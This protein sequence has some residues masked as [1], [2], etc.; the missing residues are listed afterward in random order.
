MKRKL[1][2]IL[3][4]TILLL[5][6]SIMLIVSEAV[7]AVKDIIENKVN[8]LADITLDKYENFDT[9]IENSDIGSKGVLA[10]FNLKT[11]IQ[12][13]DNENYVPIKQTKTNI[14]LPLIES[15]K[16]KRV[17][18]ITKSTQAT[19]GGKNANYKYDYSTG[20]LEI[21]A[22]N[23]EY[24]DNIADARDEY[25]IICIYSS[26]CYNQDKERDFK[27]K[28]NVE[29]TLDNE[30]ESKIY[31]TPEQEYNVKDKINGII[32]IEHKTDA[33]Y[34]GYI[35]ANALNSE[36]KYETKYNET[37]NII[38]SNKDI[39]PKI[40][41][42]ENSETSLYVESTID[43]NQ[44]LEILGDNGSIDILDDNEKILT[45]INKET[46]A[47]DNGKI[48]FTYEENKQNLNIRL[49]NIS[50]EGIIEINNVRVV[51]PT[52]VIT[53]NSIFTQ[54]T[55]NGISEVEIKKDIDTT[56][57]TEVIKEDKVVYTENNQIT[58]NI[59]KAKS[60]IDAKL[61]KYTL[62]NNT[63]NSLVYTAV[64]KA[65]GPQDSLAK[66]PNLQIQMPSGVENVEIGNAEIMYDNK[67]FKVIS[68][69]VTSNS[70]GNKVVNVQ[71]EGTQTTYENS[72]VIEGINIRIPLT[73]TLSKNIENQLGNITT[74]YSNDMNGTVAEKSTEVT[75]L[76]KIVNVARTVGAVNYNSATTA[77][78]LNETGTI[79]EQNG[80]KAEF[81]QEIGNNKLNNEATLY[82]EQIVKQSLKVT[83]TSNSVQNIKFTINVPDEMTYVIE[84]DDD[85][86]IYHEDKN[87]YE[88]SRRYE[89]IEQENKQV[90]LEMTVN[91]GET[92][93][94]FIE[95]KTKDLADTEQEK[96]S[97]ITGDLYINNAAITRLNFRNTIKQ[98]EVSVFLQ[99]TINAENHEWGFVVHVQNLTDKELKDVKVVLEADEMFELERLVSYQAGR[100][101]N[102][103][104][105]TYQY[106]IETLP[107]GVTE[108]GSLIG[109]VKEPN[110]SQ[111]NTYKLTG[112]A[113]VYGDS[114]NT[115]ISNDARANGY[116]EAVD[117]KMTA[118]KEKVKVNE[119]INYTIQISNIG[120]TW[121]WNSTY[122]EVNVKDVIPRTLK[123][124]SMTYNKF[125]INKQNVQS[126]GGYNYESQTYTEEQV[127]R[128]ISNLII[129]DG[130]DEEDAP[131]VDLDLT[132]PEGKTV[133]ITIKAKANMID[134]TTEST[135]VVNATGN[136]IKS[137][138]GS[139][140]TTVLKYDYVEPEPD[141]PEPDK[142]DPDNPD[143]D[144]PDP[145]KPDPDKPDPDKPDP[146]NPDPDKP[147]PDKPDPDNPKPD[148][149]EP[150]NPNP[151]NPE[152]DNPNPDNSTE[153]KISISG[154][155]WFDE[156][157]DGKRSVDEKTY[158][159]MTV[160]LYDYKND[161][162]VKENGQ[163]KKIQTNE[164]GEYKFSDIDKGQYI[165]IFLY[166]TQSYS[167]TEYQKVGVLENKNSDAINK[168][169]MID[170]Q[171]V[172]VGLTNSL[173]AD[174]NLT[175]IDIGLIENKS[176]DLGIQKYISKITVQT[177]DGKTKVY[178][179]N[180]KQFAKVEIR[181][182]QLTGTTVVI[183]YKMIITNNGELS[184]KVA[185]V[186]DK[187]PSG[188]TFKSELNKDW[189]E[190]NG[191]LYTNSLSGQN[192][193]VGESKEVTLVLTQNV[194]SSNVGTINNIAEIGI[195]SNDK[196]KEDE[197][198]D[199][200]SSSAQVIIGIST[201]I[202]KT[203]LITIGTILVFALIILMV[204]K[205]RE[206]LKGA[207]FIAIF[208]VCLIG[209]LKPSEAHLYYDSSN[210]PVYHIRG[211]GMHGDGTVHT[212]KGSDG[213]DLWCIDT[214]INFCNRWHGA[215][216]NENDTD[217]YNEAHAT[218]SESWS[219]GEI[220]TNV[221]L[222]LKD[223]SKTANANFSK[224]DDN[225][226]KLGPF[227][228][229]SN[230]SN[231]TCKITVY[232]TNKD[233]NTG[234]KI[235]STVE[236]FSWG[237]D[238]YIKVPSNVIK[239]SKIVVSASYTATSKKVV[240]DTHY[241]IWNTFPLH[242][243][244][245]STSNGNGEFGYDGRP[246]CYDPNCDNGQYNYTTQRFRKTIND[247][248]T[249]DVNVNLT[250]SVEI[251]GPWVLTGNLEIVKQN[252]DTSAKTKTA[253]SGVGFKI[254]KGTN[255]ANSYY[256]AIYQP[257]DKTKPISENNRVKLDKITVKTM[258]LS[259]D[260]TLGSLGV[261][262]TI[263]TGNAKYDE[264][265][266]NITY[267]VTFHHD[268]S[269]GTQIF[270]S[271][272][273]TIKIKNLEISNYVV[274]EVSNPVYGYTNLVNT[275]V[276]A[277]EF[278]KYAFV[279]TY[280]SIGVTNIKQT[281]E[282]KIDKVDYDNPSKTL[283]GATFLIK[284]LTSY[285]EERYIK[286]KV[287]EK[288]DNVKYNSTGYVT[289]VTGTAT[290]TEIAYT[291]DKNYATRFVTDSSGKLT[292]KDILVRSLNDG[293]R[294]GSKSIKYQL[295]EIKSPG[296]GYTKL[297]S[298]TIGNL[299]VAKSKEV[300]IKNVEEV[301][302][303]NIKKKD[304]DTGEG[305]LNA[306][307]I[308]KSSYNGG[309]YILVK[310]AE[311]GDNITVDSK[312]WARVVNGTSV[313]ITNIYYTDNKDIATK[314]IT[315]SKGEINIKKLLV[316]SDG[317]DT[318]TYTLEE[319]KNPNY[320][321]I[322]QT[323]KPLDVTI[324]R[325][326]NK[327]VEVKNTK[328]VGDLYVNKVDFDDPNIKLE[329]VEFVL[330]SSAGGYIRIKGTGD[331]IETGSD[332]YITRV[333]GTVKV[334][335]TPENDVNPS[336]KYTSK[337]EEATVFIADKNG[338]IYIKNLLMSTN[339]TDSITYTLEEIKNRNYAYT[340]ILSPVK[341]EIKRLEKKEIEL[342]NEKQSGDISIIKNDD[343]V[344]TKVLAGVEFVLKSSYND[345]Y[346]KVKATGDNIETDT[347]GWARRAV[348][349]VRLNDTA[350]DDTNPTIKYVE[351]R[352]EATLFVT[353]ENG[354]LVIQNLLMSSNGS[355]KISYQVEEIKNP[356]YGYLVYQDGK[357]EMNHGATFK[358]DS[359]TK[360]GVVTPKR[361]E[362][363]DITI[364][365]HQEYIRIEGY[366]WEEIA[367]GKDNR[368]NNLYD[369]GKDALIE[370]I[371][372]Y[373]YKGDQL[374]TTRT[375]DKDGKYLFGTKKENEEYEN[376]DYLTE[377]NGNLKIDDLPYYSIEFEYDGLRFTSVEA[378]ID[379]KAQN[380]DVTSKAEEV[381]SNGRNRRDRTSVNN[382]F[383]IISN[384]QS[385]NTSESQRGYELK[386]DEN[387]HTS[388]Y[389]DRWGY[390][391]NDDKTR[392]KVTPA[393]EFYPIMATTT[394]SGFSLQDAW[395]ARCKDNGAEELTGINLGV[396]RREQ[397]D[398]AIS[399]DLTEVNI[400]V[401]N[402]KDVYNNTYTYAKRNIDSED[403]FGIDVK[404]G[405]STGSYSSR[406]L[407]LY[408]RRLYE[409]D[410]ALENQKA[411]SM[412]VAIT[413]KIRVKNQSNSIVTK[414]QELVNYYDSGYEIADSWIGD[415]TGNQTAKVT[416]GTGK[417]SKAS[418]PNG[419]TA[420]YTNSLSN[421]EI[422]AGNYVD[423]Y[424]KF[425]LKHDALVQ[426]IS[427]QTTLNNVTEINAFSSINGG[428][429]YAAIDEDS[430]PGN[431]EIKIGDT[432]TSSETLNN[433][434]YQ[435]ENTTLETD[436]FE[437]DTDLAPALIMGLEVE[438][439]T[440]GLSGT[441]FEDSNTKGED[442]NATNTREE[443]IGNGI[444][445]TNEN[446]V[447]NAIVELLEYDG[448]QQD[449]IAK[450]D[451][452]NAKVATLYK[453]SVTGG[454][455]TT[456]T[457]QAIVE[458][459]D[460]GTYE[461]LGVLPGRYLIR[462]T[463]N[464]KTTINGKPI[465]PRDYKSTIIT[466]NTIKNALSLDTEP[467]RMG[468][469]NWILTY[470]GEDNQVKSKSKDAN[471]LIRYS[472]A[473]DDLDLR[474]EQEKDGIY[475]GNIEDT[476]GKMTADTAFFDVGVEYSAVKD[477][478]F[479]ERVSFTDYK[480]EYN[481]QD[482]KIVVTENGKIKLV[483]TFYAVNPCQDFG[484][485][486]R[487]RQDY[488]INKRISFIKLT[489]ANGQVLING[490]PYQEV[491]N[492]YTDW[493]NIE[494]SATGDN[495]L[496]YVKALPSQVVAEIDNELIQGATLE[497][498]YTISLKN[499]SEIDY[500]YNPDPNY[501]YY[502]KENGQPLTSVV[503]KV[504]DYM[505]DDIVYDE[506]KNSGE[507]TKV[508]AENLSAWDDNGTV[509]KLVSDVKVNNKESVAESI[510]S[511]YIISMT[512]K[513]ADMSLKPGEVASV[514]IYAGKLL[515]SN[516]KGFAADNHVEIVE[517]KRKLVGVTP[518]N[519][520]P[521]TLKQD[522]TDNSHTRISVTPP[523]GL[524]DNKIF[525][526]SMTSVI[527]VVL[528][529]GIYLIKKNVL[530]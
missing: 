439:P 509:K 519:Y 357:V 305:L 450:D 524:T 84:S 299:E 414:V 175:N 407:N 194:N 259:K 69:E 128:D 92:K 457:K 275:T 21:L 41:I 384:N 321:Y 504:V 312:G 491:G 213:A 211:V 16:P 133:T 80:I 12:F 262:A 152:P 400:K 173:N 200:D 479:N 471:G 265:N 422:Q 334:A 350:E 25:E 454:R 516:E 193:N 493:D 104:G 492:L 526:I 199:N 156:N 424:I 125:S 168:N 374:I 169:I 82:E 70:T 433:R 243:Y 192:I 1:C 226:N 453:L 36:N 364:G 387:N 33:I 188:L 362:N 257:K 298:T 182:K 520:N 404:F 161:T 486:E 294:D 40:E 60:N 252:S 109:K 399:E 435:I 485:I 178:D 239:I 98:A 204:W 361:N 455:L 401:N 477:G 9:T 273:G 500:E 267:L 45:T 63:T 34:D 180:N 242:S 421:V 263:T 230:L 118:D 375:T 212:A 290:I 160:M 176:F 355:D 139:V 167:L 461:F 527:L 191:N 394:E 135:N 385:H 277:K 369:D 308:L 293:D 406:G 246:G 405:T 113:T 489:L 386:Y 183:E 366:V 266:K 289:S 189:Y 159:N 344:D 56:E 144:K 363:E 51:L 72:T 170:G 529:G 154:V 6:S 103:S 37:M 146:D 430:N 460:K 231:A 157:E 244:A 329:N 229:N 431:A 165:V 392:L 466:S 512:E 397:V 441:V 271:T 47:D 228:V 423:V 123:P 20:S 311:S 181:S 296:Y 393:P 97:D 222:S 225:T 249:E 85:G 517:T 18:V 525:V 339:G 286:V 282:I 240:T 484:I 155:A 99:C 497:L 333:K 307:F 419:Y 87:Y 279:T 448:S 210:F 190:N 428:K 121:R 27:I 270:T 331:N 3:M 149:P 131:N 284:D 48:K 347:E 360:E 528:A 196:A 301:A 61:S 129:P 250:D 285:S 132:I 513:F 150:D 264:E 483:D 352:E 177:P 216:L 313:T 217:A 186:V 35:T 495:A 208:A 522:E 256:M 269:K 166:D 124:I 283:P 518:G 340:K 53:D 396:Q 434:T 438:E 145:D 179:Y 446:L 452:G 218:H 55:I 95:L 141:N 65:E 138:S 328:Y 437:D 73:I 224:I 5:N 325:K 38:V 445:D 255:I 530:G 68:S 502:G 353:D 280:Y 365:N 260:H 458:T 223:A 261:K 234:S 107:A 46:D 83:N 380:Y 136:N 447:E 78:T 510:K 377:S 122:T 91:A 371:T 302:D 330:K 197:N 278:Y 336:I 30:A 19:N 13:T 402:G 32:S 317:T 291:K 24:T 473:V 490:N 467:V 420:V 93:T 147:D 508:T 416:W 142:P 185:Q 94:D 488:K 381:Q 376:S 341:T 316:S 482:G 326:E 50:K 172:S 367:R 130:Y 412:N 348:G 464:N 71:L 403:N 372:V 515:S 415:S 356:N 111:N 292:I 288:G 119:E 81:I 88:L 391:Y 59:E 15:N 498:E 127:T 219:N 409:S 314:F 505:E 205:Y 417:Y 2:C 195:S 54:T 327:T 319:I 74:I 102:L 318:L 499:D 79:Y 77:T 496:P 220:N 410:L 324:K 233:G 120:R 58:T 62:A 214:G 39:A 26:E 442:P 297:T 382:D 43:K 506:E 523:T 209:N 207:L 236:S 274:R 162:F 511:G 300:T 57:D 116:V 235:V 388:T 440:R 436:S 480:D 184:G 507:W 202:G 395:E 379:Y 373:L 206:I 408:T 251:Q 478:G 7:D 368:I 398:L 370:G 11:G 358:G 134:E 432:K 247:S 470:D 337:R 187:M 287:K 148:N 476:N 108:I 106:T 163:N 171:N 201:G 143:P 115:Y 426:L 23:A 164:N 17:E 295:L 332:G 110:E 521:K 306:Q 503:K 42:K 203:I 427:K 52:A 276:Y 346:I 258:T 28:A 320:G 389:I 481:L 237:K 137:K 153:E 90:T 126:E 101:D 66:N 304:A 425:N 335:D 323:V 342:K 232:Y 462:Y 272:D 29:E 475:N 443:R 174:K 310:V 76:N 49:N 322:V 245:G 114:I 390:K 309:K 215:E 10:Q 238:F 100:V 411:G 494:K 253:G 96:K 4:L 22:E 359:I 140:L 468:N 349:K 463:Y 418:I 354:E 105:S 429:P 89:Y 117:V 465:D 67:V 31:A 343:R 383:E 158:S 151:D 449:K 472:D 64:L 112:V 474:Y 227:K 378:I 241:E 268:Q 456:N 44:V 451:E 444:F 86:E 459:S 487:P 303:L 14:D 75:L 345:K 501:Y 413:Y 198:K 469:P 338:E 514:K 351:T 254:V 315:D 221:T 8:V 248:H 281:G